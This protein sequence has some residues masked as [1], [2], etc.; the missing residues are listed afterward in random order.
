MDR[1]VMIIYFF[2]T[3]TKN[4]QILKQFD[5]IYSVLVA[6]INFQKNLILN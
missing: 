2:F 5:E 6:K 4:D 3:G 1:W